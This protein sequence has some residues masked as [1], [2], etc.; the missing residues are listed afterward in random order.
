M[1]RT[2]KQAW[3]L[4]IEA[5]PAALPAVEAALGEL[6]GALVSD[7]PEAG[8]PVSLRLYLDAEPAREWVTALLAAAALAA[9]IAPPE[10]VIEPLPETDWVAEGERALP[11]VGVGP[12]YVHGSHIA[13]PPPPGA[14]PIRIEASLAFGTGRHESTKGCLLA[15]A[16]LAKTRRFGNALDM[17]CG[18]GILAFA[19]AKLW[20]CPALGVD[21]DAR[22]VALARENAR[23]NGVAG[24]VEIAYGEGFG[25]PGVAARAPFDLI[26]ENIL[27]EAIH[28]L[29]PALKGHLAPG[30][31]ALLSGL[32]ADQ[33]GEALA[34]HAPLGLLH[35]IDLNGW[36]TLVLAR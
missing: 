33:A 7:A 11:A 31:V 30:G 26:M 29:A 8:G 15:L 28:T 17:G 10:F 1:A 20:A 3:R 27:A 18:S 22:A 21:L 14:I 36:V 4:S 32:L 5:P 23:A 19:V 13:D 16:E 9:G 24:L 25:A 34:A 2:Q 6:G 12:F 35:R